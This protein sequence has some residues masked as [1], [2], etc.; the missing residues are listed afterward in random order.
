MLEI[1]H[2]KKSYQGNPV[3]KDVS[4]SVG[5]GEIVTLL[6]NNG[7][8][9]TTIINCILK[10]VKQDAG[11]IFYAGKNIYQ[12]SDRVYFSNISALL[13]SSINVYDCLT[14]QQ[15]IAYFAGLSKINQKNNQK[16]LEY[17]ERFELS[18]HIDKPVG[19]YSRGMQ[20][21]LAIIIALLSSPKVILLDEPT[22]GLDMKSKLSVIELLQTIVAT[23]HISVILT[24]HQMDVVQK[25]NSRILLLKN[26]FVEEFSPS[27]VQNGA[28]SVSYMKDGKLI[29]E[30]VQAEFHEIYNKYKQFEI[31]EIKQTEQD[32][33]KMILERL[34]EPSE[35]G[36]QENFH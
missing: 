34:D 4:F 20:Q 2:L 23:E 15:N 3:L 19:T 31:V 18:A 11:E 5:E 21:K 1:K 35:S 6:G 14:G 29:C 7:A 22:L 10:M 26:G 13:E 33:E 28:Y 32:L 8:G 27:Y 36:I 24:T 12:I 16:I 25:L 17:I 9:K 30:T